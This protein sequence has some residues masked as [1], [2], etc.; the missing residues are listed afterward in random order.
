M[1]DVELERQFAAAGVAHPGLAADDALNTPRIM[2]SGRRPIRQAADGRGDLSR[3]ESAMAL[4]GL[5]TWG[6]QVQPPPGPPGLERQ[7]AYQEAKARAFRGHEG[8]ILR[9]MMEP[10]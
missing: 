4:R 8:E 10:R 1:C 2:P 3:A 9:T 5:L 7:L 6:E